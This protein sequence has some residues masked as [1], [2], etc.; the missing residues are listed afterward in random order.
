MNGK[1]KLFAALSGVD[2]ELLERSERGA[3]SPVRWLGW[4]M[5]LAACLAVVIAA[6]AVLPAAEQPPEDAPP[7]DGDS[8]EQPAGPIAP[9]VLPEGEGQYHL[10]Q[11]RMDRK[12]DAPGFSLFIN[13]EKYYTYEQEGVYVIQPRLSPENLPECRL[14]ISWTGT[15]PEEEA[16]NEASRL[17]SLY[18]NVWNNHSGV[19]ESMWPPPWDAYIIWADS[20]MEWDDAQRL[21]WVVGDGRGGSFIL[22]ASYFMEATEGHGAMFYDMMCTFRTEPEGDTPAWQASLE[23]AAEALIRETFSG[24]GVEA[25]VSSIDYSVSREG[26]ALTAQVF[27]RYRQGGEEPWETLELALS[28][29]GDGVWSAGALQ[30]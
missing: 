13:E 1:E 21:T 11:F 25:S 18:E 17:G 27:V 14:E 16:G 5:A 19:V 24:M 29:G 12:Q 22:S 28:C 20:G 8:V 30:P 10:L 6:A 9:A 15:P 3:G 4:G 23:E 2:E 26:D 7:T